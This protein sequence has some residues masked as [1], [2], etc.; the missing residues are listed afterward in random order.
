MFSDICNSSGY[1]FVGIG[2]VSMSALARL[3]KDR[4]EKVRGSDEREGDFTRELRAFGIPVSIGSDEEIT[5]GTVVYTGA[6]S[7]GHKQIVAAKRAGKRLIGRAEF[8]G[9]VAEDFPH[10]LSVAGCHGKTT[11]CC[12]LSHVFLRSGRAFTSHIGGEDSAL[13]NYASTGRDYFL[14][15]ACEFQRSFLHLKS[16][17][18][19][20]LNCDKDHTDCYKSD[21]E[22]KT[23]YKTFASQA[24]RVVVNADDLTARDIPHELSFG[25]HAGDIR[26]EQFRSD[27]E[28]YSFTITERDI[29]VVRVRLK[30]VGRVHAYNA[31]AAFAAARL[32]G[33]SADEI[34]RGL[35]D[36][37]GVK[38]RFEWVGRINGAPVICDYAHHP[39][40]IAATLSTAERLC[41]GHLHVVFQPH[42]YT[43]TR[44]FMEDFVT[45]LGRCDHLLL[46]KTYAARERFDIEGSAAM[47]ASRIPQ[48]GYVQTRLQLAKRLTSSVE[49]GDMILV[50]GAGDIYDIVKS[51]LD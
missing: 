16:E 39:R 5:E 32:M 48:A 51:I 41:D 44:D 22:L 19:V 42:T 12:M 23:A 47:L 35:E 27:G 43:R 37:T 21:E 45:V 18:A 26:A 10:V 14:T 20:I 25:L 34:K 49:E 3:I 13:G 31:L 33:F 8:L 28:R 11:T 40:E 38:R 36:F 46:Y 2:G 17:V 50:L 9:R 29:P 15:E 4:G 1:Y 6:I 30:A 7:E 24:S